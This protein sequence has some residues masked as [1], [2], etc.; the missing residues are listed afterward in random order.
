MKSNIYIFICPLLF[1]DR[2]GKFICEDTTWIMDLHKLEPI[3]A[4]DLVLI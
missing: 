3:I 4:A 1:F 2:T